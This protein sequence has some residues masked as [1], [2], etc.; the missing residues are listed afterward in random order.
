VYSARPPLVGGS[1]GAG[2]CGAVVARRGARCG[3]RGAVLFR[4]VASTGWTVAQDRGPRCGC[5]PRLRDRTAD[6]DHARRGAGGRP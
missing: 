3:A 6:G 2:R 5:R 1:V 4:R